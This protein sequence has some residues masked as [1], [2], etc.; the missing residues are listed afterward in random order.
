[1]RYPHSAL[2][3]EAKLSYAANPMTPPAVLDILA[4]D[5]NWVVRR[6]LA[7]HAGLSP[8]AFLILS[9]DP[10][11]EVR[12]ELAMNSALPKDIAERLAKDRE[13]L[14]RT[15]LARN[16]NLSLDLA[17]FL[18][19][20][21][22]PAVREALASRD[23][24]YPEV[25]HLLAKDA[26]FSVRLRLLR[27]PSTPTEAVLTI[28]KG[29]DELQALEA[30]EAVKP[31]PYMAQREIA[32]KGSPFLRSYLAKAPWIDRDVWEILLRD[33]DPFVAQQAKAN[34]VYGVEER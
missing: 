19:R 16:H 7:S 3:L 14:V 8:S 22:N 10:H 11:P 34:P 13:F 21:S 18:A 24:L 30:M 1:M 25:A 2:S 15:A 17:L 32:E 6:R 31:L 9:R 27:N 12:M 26:S 23:P 5:E 29:M 20:D 4:M 28:L 33:P